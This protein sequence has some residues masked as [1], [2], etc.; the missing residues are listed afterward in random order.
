VR[1]ERPLGRV[2]GGASRRRPRFP[3]RRVVPQ[4][5]RQRAGGPRIGFDARDRS[6]ATGLQEARPG[7][8]SG[9]LLQVTRESWFWPGGRARGPAGLGGGGGA[10]RSCPARA[11]LSPGVAVHDRVA[12]GPPGGEQIAV[13]AGD[14]EVLLGGLA[15]ARERPEVVDLEGAGGPASLAVRE[16]A[17]TS[18]PGPSPDRSRHRRGDV[19]R[20]VPRRL[21][22]APR[23]LD[24]GALPPRLCQG[25]VEGVLDD[26]GQAAARDDVG[27]DVPGG[28]ELVEYAPREGNRDAGAIGVE[29]GEGQLPP[30]VRRSLGRGSRFR[31]R[32]RRCRCRRQGERG[33]RDRGLGAGRR[34]RRDG[35]RSGAARCGGK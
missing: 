34:A 13:P 7:T 35:G 12:E 4:E 9:A 10:G 18:S 22:S 8:A 19:A 25:E 23:L 31:R 28:L 15:A 24:E 5:S 20:A 17:L 29:E 33:L 3:R 1:G 26:V 30:G 11:A 32:N 2:G 14:P 16:D 21:R 6:R 27:E